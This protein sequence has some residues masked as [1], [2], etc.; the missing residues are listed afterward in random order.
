[1]FQEVHGPDRDFASLSITDLLQARDQYHFHLMNKQHVVGTAIGLY[2]IREHDPWPT[3][4]EPSKGFEQRPEAPKEE[5]TFQ[6]SQVRDYSWP[7]VMV[8]V[9]NWVKAFGTN[10]GELHP[11]DMVPRT[12]YLPDGRMVPV[13]VVKVAPTVARRS[14]P[15]WQWPNGA[16]G[17]GFPLIV[18]HQG[19]RKV[20]SIGCLVTD[21]HTTYALTNRHVCGEPG[22]PIF[23]MRRGKQIEIGRSST[24]QAT[25]VPF[26]DVYPDF[27]SRRTYLNFDIGL[28]EIHDVNLWTSEVFGLGKT[29]ALADFYEANMGLK[30]IE[31]DVVAH[32]AASGYM[33]GK[34]KGLFHRYRSV[35]GYDYVADFLIAP[36]GDFQTR[37]GDSGTVWHLVTKDEKKELLP[38]A[39]EWGAQSFVSTGGVQ[40]FQL[41]LATSLSN[42]CK[43]LDVELVDEAGTGARP[44]WG[45]LGHYSI[46]A[47]ACDGIHNDKLRLL[48]TQ[49]RDRV[50]FGLDVLTPKQIAAAIKTAKENNDFIPLA[51]VP[52]L[53]WKALPSKIAGGRDYPAG[54]GR[55]TGPEHPVHYAD[56]DEPNADGKTL[57]EL[58]L[59]DPTYLTPAKWTAFYTELG[60][61]ADYK[62]HG[63]LPFRIWQFFDVMK[64]ALVAGDLDRFV[65]AAGTLAHYVGDACQTLHGSM[66]ADGYANQPTTVTVHHRDGT[67]TDEPSHVG[68][69]IHSAFETN[70]VDRYAEE[71]VARVPGRIGQAQ[72]PALPARIHTGA[73]AAL[74]TIALMERAAKR[75]PPKDLVDAYVEAGGVKRVAVYDV[76]WEQFQDQTVDSMADGADVL[77]L[78]WEGA[79]LAG[80]G[81]AQ[82]NNA[83]LGPRDFDALRAIYETKQFA[84]SLYLR[85]IAPELT[86]L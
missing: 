55:T 85:D 6:N 1:M 84:P 73:E 79:W 59:A 37:M 77:A 10:K 11:Q 24:K 47:F 43:H 71:I 9:D 57:R 52:D 7:C 25:R 61:G 21:G 67:V 14:V 17:P 18:E 50:S 62:H 65:C 5:R 32:G 20:A 36:Q 22:Q 13:C 4:K 46:G 83:A 40:Q 27:P 82:F 60:H 19:A 23:S 76:L 78:I 42:V 35:G 58:C 28:V 41:A 12:L 16:I 72:Q 64:T 53:V 48:M 3:S 75:I 51:D 15:S 34:I 33:Q 2:L 74:A 45:Q 29:G 49:N 56:I 30:L 86:G 69:G 63:L 66:Y 80:D 81:D 68:K 70:M 26:S 44:Y 38:L 8:L 39:I 54:N 31:A